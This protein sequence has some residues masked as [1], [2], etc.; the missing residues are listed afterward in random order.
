[1][2]QRHFAPEDPVGRRIHFG[3]A[4][5]KNPWITIVGVV[6]DVRSERIEY[7]PLRQA[8]NLSLSLVLKTDGDPRQVGPA[9]AREVRAADP[10]QPTFGV[11]TMDAI[12]ASATASRRFATQ[13]LGAFAALALLLA[14]SGS[15]G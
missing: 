6:D 12:V 11:K 5:S 10:D 3:G 1:M 9:L 7:R 2:A 8:S 13:L 15:T 14:R 4:E